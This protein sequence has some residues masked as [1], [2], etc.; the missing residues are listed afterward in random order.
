M[1][2]QGGLEDDLSGYARCQ[3]RHGGAHGAVRVLRALV[4]LTALMCFV[5]AG[6]ATSAGAVGLAGGGGHSCVLG[7]S[8]HVDCWGWNRYSQ[9][10]DG[11]KTN[12]GTPVEV[13]GV[14][15]A[16]QLAAGGDDSCVVLPS[17]HIDC[18]GWNG[19][20]QLGDGTE[21]NGLEPGS[22]RL[23]CSEC[24]MRSRSRRATTRARC[25]PPATS[26][27]GAK[28]TTG[29][30]GMA[31]KNAASFRLKCMGSPA[32][33]RS[34]QAGSARA[35]CYLMATS[36]AGV[37]GKAV[38]WE[39]AP[40]PTAAFPLKCRGSPTPPRYRQA[41]LMRVRCFPAAASTA[42]APTTTGSSGTGPKQT[43]ASRSK[44][45]ESLTPTRWWRAKASANTRARCCPAATSTAGA[46]TNPGSSE[47]AEPRAAA[48]RLKCRVSPTPPR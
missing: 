3:V 32:R 39:M 36:I 6:A 12:S 43:A 46:G 42:G 29:R 48:S 4:V 8:G 31:R 37:K 24:R 40:R 13:Q 7:S 19:Y 45:R 23:K 17:G 35:R 1:R 47:T 38:S 21:E 14:S 10:G 11:T 34:R 18:W 22:P 25:C 26:T 20:G 2:L 5:G 41:A 9:L 15:D 28:A 33:C 16:V 30:S 27:A 44:S